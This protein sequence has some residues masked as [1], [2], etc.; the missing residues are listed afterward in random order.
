MR[1]GRR[2][3]TLSGSTLESMTLGRRTYTAP[4]PNLSHPR[5]PPAAGPAGTEVSSSNPHGSASP[6]CCSRAGRFLARHRERTR[7]ARRRG[8]RR[9]GRRWEGHG[10]CGARMLSAGCVMAGVAEL[11]P[12]MRSNSPH[13]WTYADDGSRQRRRRAPAPR[14]KGS[15]ARF[16]SPSRYV[17]TARL[18]GVLQRLVVAF[19]SAW[20]QHAARAA[21]TTDRRPGDVSRRGSDIGASRSP[22]SSAPCASSP[23]FPPNAQQKR[24]RNR[25]TARKLV[26][27]YGE[28]REARLTR[29]TGASGAGLRV[30]GNMDVPRKNPS[31]R[32]RARPGS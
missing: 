24:K 28:R 5:K 11:G 3:R 21:R 8:H 23:S 30:G 10:A 20:K 32:G 16:S 18:R 27:R 19:V 4:V 26:G 17:V 6:A 15:P 12:G 13:A 22:P 31:R 14:A 7:S 9:V 25:S 29:S 1:D 2:A